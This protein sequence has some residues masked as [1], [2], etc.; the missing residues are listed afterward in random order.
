MRLLA[1]LTF[2]ATA[3]LAATGSLAP[4][5]PQLPQG[6]AS[7]P[8]DLFV[9]RYFQQHNFA[10]PSP[11]PDAIFA[12]RAS[13][14]V[15]GLLPSPDQYKSFAEDRRPDKRP[16]LVRALLADR[17]QYAEHW[18]SFWNDLLRNDE[19]VIYHGLRETI[20]AWLFP[21]IESNMPYDRFVKALLHPV[22]PADPKGFLIGV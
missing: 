10:A 6:T 8:I 18:V 11:V 2:L 3:S 17:H 7:N 21:A 14:D 13:L 19:G 12:R 15:W 5:R 20:S 9:Q 4:R 1:A 16:R 22:T